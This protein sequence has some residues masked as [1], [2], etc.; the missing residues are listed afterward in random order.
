MTGLQ[1]WLASED[2]HRTGETGRI[3]DTLS[4]EGQTRIKRQRLG[5]GK[6][7]PKKK[8]KRTLSY[9]RENDVYLPISLLCF[10]LLLCQN[11]YFLWTDPMDRNARQ[12]YVSINTLPPSSLSSSLSPS[13]V[14]LLCG[15]VRLT[16]SS[17][18]LLGSH[19]H[20]DRP[21]P[22]LSSSP[23]HLSSCLHAPFTNQLTPLLLNLEMGG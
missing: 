21:V 8:K 1:F 4:P 20:P 15:R 17:S 10:V 7:D 13:F 12:I 18:C 16:V 14:L 19:Y 5:K 9:L 23:P 6:R 3:M 11:A 22:V 2:R